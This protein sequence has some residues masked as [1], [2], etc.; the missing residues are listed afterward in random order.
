MQVR[1][2]ETI[3]LPCLLEHRYPFQ[4]QS[5]GNHIITSHSMLKR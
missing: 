5:F 1:V 2:V 3:H 4:V